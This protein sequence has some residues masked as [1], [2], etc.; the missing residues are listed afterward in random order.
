MNEINETNEINGGE[1]KIWV[2]K[3]GLSDFTIKIT[4]ED[5]VITG[6]EITSESTKKTDK[7]SDINEIIEIIEQH[8]NMVGYPQSERKL[9]GW[10]A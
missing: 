2:K 7:F 9:R 5:G 8:C 6:G 1:K 10:D 4:S 3:R